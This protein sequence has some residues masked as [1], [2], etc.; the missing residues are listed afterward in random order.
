MMMLSDKEL[1]DEY[2]YICIRLKDAGDAISSDNIASAC[3]ILGALHQYCFNACGEII[4]K[5]KSIGQ[6]IDPE[7]K[8]ALFGE[9]V[10][11]FFG[12]EEKNKE[13]NES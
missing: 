3:W 13:I 1:K 4:E 6:K 10:K 8:T 9:K 12:F 11:D 2:N 7:I 5:E